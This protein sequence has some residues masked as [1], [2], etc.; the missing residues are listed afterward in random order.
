MDCLVFLNGVLH[1]FRPYAGFINE[2]SYDLVFGQSLPDQ[3]GFNFRGKMDML[4]LYDYGISYEEVKEIYES[5]I[6]FIA[7]LSDE[8]SILHVYPNPASKSIWVEHKTGPNTEIHVRLTSLTGKEILT[9]DGISD[10]YGI[11][12]LEIPTANLNA[13]VYLISLFKGQTSISKKV[14]K[15]D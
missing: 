8:K 11:F 13:G 15:T 3:S 1:G 7:D 5:E 12:R 2:T 10:Q 14:V 4:R 6:S 9:I